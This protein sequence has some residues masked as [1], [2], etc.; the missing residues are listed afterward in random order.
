MRTQTHLPARVAHCN[1]S[2]NED[3]SSASTNERFGRAMSLVLAE[4]TSYLT[5]LV[6][7]WWPARQ[8]VAA[9]FAERTQLHPSG[10]VLYLKTYCPWTD[11]LFQLEEEEDVPGLVKYV[12]YDDAKGS[13]VR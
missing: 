5:R 1:P 2:W 11:H 9:A 7:S 12:L 8:L 10:Q 13:M 4:F 6:Q 3:S